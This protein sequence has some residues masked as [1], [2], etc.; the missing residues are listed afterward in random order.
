MASSASSALARS[1]AR[2]TLLRECHLSKML[3]S[4][5]KTYYGRFDISRVFTLSAL[6]KDQLVY[7]H[8]CSPVA[9]KRASRGL[10]RSVFGKAPEAL[11]ANFALETTEH[12]MANVAKI[13]AWLVG[14]SPTMACAERSENKRRKLKVKVQGPSGGAKLSK[15][16]RVEAEASTPL[17]NQGG[18]VVTWHSGEAP[19]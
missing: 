8:G 19:P 10:P 6:S 7:Y 4:I 3:S 1:E 16:E 15:K 13:M 18:V 2:I 11:W 14:S 9:M 12:I 17:L 5:L